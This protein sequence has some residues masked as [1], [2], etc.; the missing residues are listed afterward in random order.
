M[1][2][3]RF[4][5]YIFLDMWDRRGSTLDD[6]AEGCKLEIYKDSKGEYRW[7]LKAR[8]R[9]V[10]AASGEGYKRKAALEKSFGLVKDI[11]GRVPVEWV[12]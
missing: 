10:I 2:D 9:R 8:N 1:L 5:K 3:F 11:I 4:L 7:R 12:E 6:L